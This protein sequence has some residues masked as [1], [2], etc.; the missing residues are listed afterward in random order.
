MST[1]GPGYDRIDW[2]VMLR[3]RF[4]EIASRRVLAEDVESVVTE[5]MRAVTDS[6]IAPGADASRPA[7]VEARRFL[8]G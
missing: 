8:G 2:L 1:Q 5:A 7:L 3:E 6:E 4:T